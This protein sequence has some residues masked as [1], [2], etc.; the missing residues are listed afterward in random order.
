MYRQADS[1]SAAIDKDLNIGLFG[2]SF[3][4][5]GTHPILA[6]LALQ[7]PAASYNTSKHNGDLLAL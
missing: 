3:G 6:N 4:H 5:F 1:A 7:S 2:S